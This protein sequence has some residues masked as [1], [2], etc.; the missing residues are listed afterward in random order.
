MTQLINVGFD[1]SL[2]CEVQCSKIAF[3]YSYAGSQ[4]L[5][6]FTFCITINPWSRDLVK[7]VDPQLDNKLTLRV[8]TE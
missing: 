4:I 8:I 6:N 2:L 1:Y 7:L 3:L 5:R